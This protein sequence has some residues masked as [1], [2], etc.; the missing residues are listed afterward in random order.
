MYRKKITM[1]FFRV[2]QIYLRKFANEI[3]LT[4]AAA[5]LR[6]KPTTCVPVRTAKAIVYDLD[7]P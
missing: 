1:L 3:R 2:I 4:A 7:R 6:N 5:L